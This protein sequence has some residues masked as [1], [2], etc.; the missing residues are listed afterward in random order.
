[1]F[2]IGWAEFILVALVLLIFVGPKHLPSMLQK[3]G[4]IVSELRSASRELRSQ[5]EVEVKD[6]ESPGKIARDIGRDMMRDMP[7]PYNEIRE[8]EEQLK[9]TIDD[10]KESLQDTPP[11][12]KPKSDED[13]DGKE[14][15]QK[16]DIS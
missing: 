8:T 3:F 6:I 5:I 9:Q 7:S 1:V 4:Q 13:V 14:E 12:E 11:K 15:P 16:E 2:G 10:T